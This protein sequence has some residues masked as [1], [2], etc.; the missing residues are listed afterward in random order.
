MKLLVPF[1]SLFLFGCAAQEIQMKEMP[2]KLTSVKKDE[3]E[4][5]ESL[6]LKWQSLDGNISI[7]TSAPIEDS[8][9]Y[10]TGNVYARCFLK[11]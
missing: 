10:V 2:L 5:G 3:T 7:V 4:Q 9:E 8:S 1:I 6:T 11:K